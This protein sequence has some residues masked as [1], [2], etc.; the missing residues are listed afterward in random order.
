MP[1]RSIL[2]AY[3]VVSLCFAPVVWA[4]SMKTYY[5]NGTVQMEI[6]DEGQKTYYEDGQLMSEVPMKDGIPAGV[7]KYY[8][9]DGKVMREDDYGKKH[10]KQ[11]NQEGQMIAEGDI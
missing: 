11:F 9:P 7:G 5:P 8:Y 2:I 4:Q 3:S 1:K 6:S 10:W